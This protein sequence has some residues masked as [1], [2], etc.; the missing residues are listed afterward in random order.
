MESVRWNAQQIEGQLEAI[1][2]F[3]KDR[4]SLV[5]LAWDHEEMIGY[6]SA[7]FYGWNRLGQIHGL[8]VHPECRRKGYAS[9]LV[10]EVEGFMKACRARGVYVDTPVNNAAGCAFYRSN[11]FK[12][13]YVMPEYYDEGV[14]GIT[15]LKLYTE[16]PC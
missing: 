2:K 14:D 16:N 11:D 9:R 4:H 15:F 13:A 12:E 6:I 10:Q 8:V 1:E 7:Q 5:I 3:L